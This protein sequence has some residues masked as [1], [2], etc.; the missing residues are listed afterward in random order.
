LQFLLL[1]RMLQLLLIVVLN[2]SAVAKSACDSDEVC[3]SG[4]GE[5]L[6]GCV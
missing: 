3:G 4:D 2:I 1:L 6:M 5:C